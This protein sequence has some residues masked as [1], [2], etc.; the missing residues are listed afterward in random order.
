M[1]SDL[2]VFMVGIEECGLFNIVNCIFIVNF[3]IC[4]CEWMGELV[5]DIV[6]IF[7]IGSVIVVVFIVIDFLR[8]VYV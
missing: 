6:Y 8:F 1:I 3:I 4:F 7:V 2:M 5:N